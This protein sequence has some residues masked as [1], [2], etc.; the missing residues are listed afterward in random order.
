M[1]APT[2]NSRADSSQLDNN[3]PTPR[4]LGVALAG[5]YYGVMDFPY[6][7]FPS[8]KSDNSESVI[9]A[10][11]MMA[12]VAYPRV[13]HP[14]V[15]FR[16]VNPGVA[17][18]S[19]GST[20]AL[21]N[22]P[23]V[24]LDDVIHATYKTPSMHPLQEWEGWVV[25]VGDHE[26][27]ARLTDLTAEPGAPEEEA[28]I[29]NSEISEDDLKRLRQGDIFRWV[30]GYERWPSGTKKRVSQIVFRDLPIMTSQDKSMGEEWARNVSQ[31]L[32][33]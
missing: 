25:E 1:L 6:G 16:D 15:D 2:G 12:Q 10:L 28:I 13:A 26:F 4:I 33:D 31:A 23:V 7:E 17:G 18:G 3:E 21:S 14:I 19:S 32:R 8:D 20:E 9:W 27:V 22:G 11:A 5:A 24:Q 29:P 30:I